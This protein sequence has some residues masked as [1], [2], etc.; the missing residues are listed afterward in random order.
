MDF[1]ESSACLYIVNKED[2]AEVL[3]QLDYEEEGTVD[4][5]EGSVDKFKRPQ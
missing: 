5:E 1:C 4:K 3:D 2:P